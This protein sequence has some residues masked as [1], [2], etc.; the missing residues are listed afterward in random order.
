LGLKDFALRPINYS[1]KLQGLFKECNFIE[2]V[3]FAIPWSLNIMPIYVFYFVLY[4]IFLIENMTNVFIWGLI[5]H[6]IMHV[7]LHIQNIFFIIY[8]MKCLL[9]MHNALHDS[10]GL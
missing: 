8:T 6:L 5:M 1:S 4:N 3:P 10:N 7:Q 2:V 9:N